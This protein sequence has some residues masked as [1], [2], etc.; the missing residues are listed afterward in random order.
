MNAK[1]AGSESLKPFAE[2]LFETAG[3]EDSFDRLKRAGAKESVLLKLLEEAARPFDRTE[4]KKIDHKQKQLD[5]L[6]RSLDAILERVQKLDTFPFPDA[7]IWVELLGVRRPPVT[8]SE[9]EI[10][11]QCAGY[12][13]T[14]ADAYR[15]YFV[16]F[17]KMKY[18][19]HVA[20]LS[21]YVEQAT[22]KP[23]DREVAHLLSAAY[24]AFDRKGADGDGKFFAAESIKN[25]RQNFSKSS[26]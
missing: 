19:W 1:A 20:G 12:A 15:A 14:N 3:A 9:L 23:H 10:L 26:K 7:A 2:R 5:G 6:A 24:A 21:G 4:K 13:R 25:A 8:P 16:Q 22:G 11:R 17:K 18:R